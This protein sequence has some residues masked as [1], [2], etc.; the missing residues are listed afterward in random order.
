MERLIFAGCKCFQ[1][2]SIA[3]LLYF[4]TSSTMHV[5]LYFTKRN[6]FF[7]FCNVHCSLIS[8][9]V[10]ILALV[11]IKYCLESMRNSVVFYDYTRF[12][13]KNRSKTSSAGGGVFWVSTNEMARYRVDFTTVRR[14][15]VGSTIR[16]R[17]QKE[18]STAASSS[19]KKLEHTSLNSVCF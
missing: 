1:I 3:C 7:F 8:E 11:Y 4:R 18:F 5:S 14:E 19:G 6:S 12:Y 13:L 17:N 2:M 16:E 15:V 9:S 10:H